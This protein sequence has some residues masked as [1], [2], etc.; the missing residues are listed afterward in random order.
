MHFFMK[1]L[2]VVV[3][4]F[5]ISCLCTHL[6]YS[7]V[8][9]VGSVTATIGVENNTSETLAVSC[10]FYGYYFGPTQTLLPHT[11]STPFQ[12]TYTQ[13]NC[14]IYNLDVTCH[15]ASEQ[16]TSGEFI[17]HPCPASGGCPISDF[18][19]NDS[20]NTHPLHMCPSPQCTHGNDALYR[21][22]TYYQ[23]THPCV[24]ETYVAIN[25]PIKTYV[26]N[27][28][29]IHTSLVQ[30]QVLANKLAINLKNPDRYET[31]VGAYNANTLSI[32]FKTIDKDPFA[33][34]NSTQ[35]C[36]IDYQS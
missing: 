1:K 21:C 26:F 16:G 28:A 34:D 30:G 19:A 8:S 12:G 17:F 11:S 22:G 6:A 7:G 29:N 32:K 18:Q 36:K 5:L 33:G 24:F 14:P 4:I 35:E 27:W 25:E 10:N 3:P 23:Q 13:G 9:N 20:T 15:Y 2:C 31:P